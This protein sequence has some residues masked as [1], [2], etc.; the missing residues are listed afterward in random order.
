MSVTERLKKARDW[1]ERRRHPRSATPV[2]TLKLDGQTYKAVDWSLGGCRIQGSAGQF[3]INQRVSGRVKLA[4]ADGRGAFVAEV[5][6]AESD[7]QVALRWLEISPHIFVTMSARQ[8][9]P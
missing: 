5:M 1:V 9:G 4:G 8:T 6:R 3:R 7:G 2:L